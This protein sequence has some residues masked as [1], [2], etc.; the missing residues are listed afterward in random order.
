MPAGWAHTDIGTVPFAGDATFASGTYTVR[1]SGA[2][3]WGTAD[4]FDNIVWGT[5][6]NLLDNIVWGTSDDDNIVWGTSG[7]DETVFPNE[8]TESLPDVTSE[9]G[10]L[11]SVNGVN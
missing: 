7:E 6:A 3:V 8:E 4:Q 11:T 2:D 5:A 9:F 1:G 10:D